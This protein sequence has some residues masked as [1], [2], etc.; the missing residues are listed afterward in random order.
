M[1]CVSI[2]MTETHYLGGLPWAP[3]VHWRQKSSIYGCYTGQHLIFSCHTE[4][5]GLWLPDSSEVFPVEELVKTDPT[6]TRQNKA[7][8]PKM[9][10]LSRA[11]GQARHGAVLPGG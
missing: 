6:L 9:S 8:N 1:V 5:H 4:Q 7:I 2:K 10:S 3:A 11:P